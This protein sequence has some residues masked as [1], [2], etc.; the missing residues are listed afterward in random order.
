[1]R[2]YV[3]LLLFFGWVCLMILVVTLVPRMRGKRVALLA[4]ATGLAEVRVRYTGEVAAQWRGDGVTWVLR[5]GG[6]SGPERAVIDIAAATPARLVIRKRLRWNLDLSLFGPPVI[7]SPTAD[8]FIVRGDDIMLA[9]RVLTDEF[10]MAMLPSVVDER[11]DELSFG[12]SRV[13]VINVK[14]TS[15]LDEAFRA[16]WQLATTVV[17]RLGLPPA[18]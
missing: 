6:K 3:P 2:D 1:M 16:A 8:R 12:T 11:I 14:R 9:E 10:I 18:G 17:E 13:R 4:A 7:Q 15:S 5:G